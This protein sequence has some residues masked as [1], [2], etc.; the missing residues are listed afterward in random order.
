MKIAVVG[1]T[2][3]KGKT[4]H[5]NGYQKMTR[6]VMYNINKIAV[7]HKI[8]DVKT[9]VTLV[10]GGAAL[11]DHIAVDLF[12]EGSVRDLVLYL[13]CPWNEK[14]CEFVHNEAGRLANAL[15]KT[16]SSQ[17]GRN[18]LRDI[19]LAID[20]GCTV[21]VGQGFHSRNTLLANNADA[22]I[23]FTFDK[24]MTP[25]TK[26]VWGECKSDTKIHLIIH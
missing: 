26:H 16:F 21:V 2:P 19:Q 9:G 4:I 1:S 13:P 20:K 10:S 24:T 25:G 17:I 5:L 14:Q 8:D 23:A 7:D 15:H 6:L 3:K 12:L 22:M 18:S 11:S